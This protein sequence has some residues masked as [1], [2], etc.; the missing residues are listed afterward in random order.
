MQEKV[1]DRYKQLNE[2]A[3]DISKKEFETAVNSQIES[4][5]NTLSSASGAKLTPEQ[6]AELK[7]AMMEHVDKTVGDI[8]AK[9]VANQLNACVEG[10]DVMKQVGENL[11]QTTADMSGKINSKSEIERKKIGFD[12]FRSFLD[13]VDNKQTG[14]T[15]E[16]MGAPATQAPAK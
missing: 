7:T 15:P 12:I 6:F 16:G 13:A 4:D 14:R 9:N 10:V 8:I 3:I 11:T 5:F 2:Q 1:L